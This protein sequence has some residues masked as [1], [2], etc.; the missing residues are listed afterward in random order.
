MWKGYSVEPLPDA[1]HYCITLYRVRKVQC[2]IS[3]LCILVLLH[4]RIMYSFSK[5]T[6]ISFTN[7]FLRSKNT[8]KA[9]TMKLSA[10]ELLDILQSFMLWVP[11]SKLSDMCIGI[12]KMCTFK[13]WKTG[14]SEL[15]TT[16]KMFFFKVVYLAA[17]YFFPF[18]LCSCF[19]E[20]WQRK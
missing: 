19:V 4:V 18:I 6:I 17:F 11:S 5:N 7:C 8:F 9:M 16:A 2:R 13:H 15:Q 3:Y 10:T 1:G 12:D 14:L 20:L